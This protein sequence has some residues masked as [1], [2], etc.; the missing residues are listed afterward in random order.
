MLVGELERLDDTD[1]LLDGAADGEVVDVHGAKGALGVDEEGATEGDALLGEEDTVGLGDGVVA[2]SEETELQV[3]AEA[4]LLAGSLRP[5]EVGEL[6]VSRE[7]N[8]L[9]VDGLE[10]VKSVVEREDLGGADDCRVSRRTGKVAQRSSMQDDGFQQ[11]SVLQRDEKRG[12]RDR[13]R[14]RHVRHEECHTATNPQYAD[15]TNR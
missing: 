11:A 12:G 4:A 6:G 3:G 8:D 15:P 13:V 5:G 2:V 14:F 10:L 7:G 9:G 1:R